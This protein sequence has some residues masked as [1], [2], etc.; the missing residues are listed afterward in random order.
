MGISVNL[1]FRCFICLA[2]GAVYKEFGQWTQRKGDSKTISINSL[3]CLI[4]LPLHAASSYTCEKCLV[5]Q[6]KYHMKEKLKYYFS[7]LCLC[8]L[9]CQS[10]CLLPLTRSFLKYVWIF[11]FWTSSAQ[12]LPALLCFDKC[13]LA[14]ASWFKGL[15][16]LWHSSFQGNIWPS[17][18]PN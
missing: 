17:G 11:A 14:S 2:S 7:H 5:P 3:Q 12:T 15:S 16:L 6:F 18:F 10:L 13:N 4:A 8:R 9:R 1:G